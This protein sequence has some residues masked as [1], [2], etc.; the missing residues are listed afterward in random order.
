MEGPGFALN[1]K[2]LLILSGGKEAISGI[3][4][5]KNM[6][7]KVV[8]ADGDSNAP[9]KKYA[10]IFLCVNIYSPKDTLNAVKIFSRKNKIDGVI[11]IATDNPTSVAVVANYLG[12]PGPS[13]ET[14]SIS[15]NKVQMKDIFK[16]NSIPIPW[17]CSITSQDQLEQIIKLR[18]DKYVLKPSDSRGSRGVIRLSQLDKVSEAWQY[19]NKH[20]NSGILILEEWLYGEQLSSESL[21]WRE[22]SY[23]CGLADRKYDRLDDLYPYVVEDGGETPS[24][25]SPNIDDSIDRL[26]TKAAVAI[27]LTNGSI[28]GDIVKTKKGLFIIEVAARLSG[29]YFSTDTI[30]NVYHY[31]IIEQIIKIA[32]GL[33][34][35]LPTKPLINHKFQANRFLFLN[36]GKVVSIRHKKINDDE[37]FY[38]DLYVK[39]GEIVSLINNHTKRGG[40]ALAISNSRSKAI[41]KCK[42]AIENMLVDQS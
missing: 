1:I 16:K 3:I 29:G 36:P 9:G 39:E 12:L 4:T 13:L 27:G 38:N 18:P 33:T 24:K 19:S 34:P 23:L 11:A 22:E 6:D 37:L 30:P 35:S 42:S 5:A 21:V 8:V 14:A 2:T 28:K 7:L 17:Y 40:M 32:L 41:K 26:M 31:S 20:S 10:D 15:S 25:Y